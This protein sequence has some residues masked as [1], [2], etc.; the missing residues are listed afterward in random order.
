MNPYQ[1]FNNYYLRTPLLSLSEYQR[2][3]SKNELSEDDFKFILK[4]PI[5]RE[6]VF[7]ASPELHNQIE[8][9][10]KG[11]LRNPKKIERLKLSI[12]KYFTRISSR[13]TPFGLFAA[14]ELGSFGES[15]SI[16]L[17][18]VEQYK[19][20][21]RFD[22]AFLTQLSS[23][24][25]NDSVIR[26]H[27]L[28]YPNTSIYLIG[29]Q[30]R[31]HEYTI[32]KGRR[33]YSLEGILNSEYIEKVLENAKEGK[34]IDQLASVLVNEEVAFEEAKEFVSELVN[35]QVLM[36]ELEV[37]V[38]GE[39]Y[40][41]NLT[42]RISAYNS[43]ELL[44]GKLKELASSLSYID[45]S[46]G[47]SLDSYKAI[48]K[49]VKALVSDYN[50]NHLFQTDTFSS[51]VDNVLDKGVKKKLYNALKV[52]NKLTPRTARIRLIEFKRSF[53]KR[54]EGQQIPLSLVLDSETG[55]GYGDKQE[56]NTPLL[57][58]I[59]L[60]EPKKRYE[61]FVW[62]DV[63]NI[64]Q[65][66]LIET[67]SSGKTVMSLTEEDLK[68]IPDNWE[69]LPDTF[70][71]MIEIHKKNGKEAVYI[72]S[73]G[74]STALNL[75]GRFTE[76]DRKLFN[77]CKEIKEKEQQYQGDKIVAE[78]VHVPEARTGNV[79]H[80]SA[81]GAY[82]IPYLGKSCLSKSNQIPLEDIL[83][84]VK[85]DRVILFS[86][87]YQKEI[88]PKLSNA[89]NF[90]N[91]SLPIYQFLCDLQSQYLRSGL[92]FSWNPVLEKQ[93]FLP[94]VVFEDI[95]LCKAKWRI[96]T[97]TLHELL[98][99]SR[100]ARDI[101]KW[102]KK[103]QIPDYVVLKEG[104][105]ALLVYLKNLTSLQMLYSAVK[106]KESFVLEEHLFSD[107]EWVQREGELFC[108]QGIV[109]FYKLKG[110]TEPGTN[111]MSTKLNSSSKNDE[112]LDVSGIKETYLPGEEWLYYKVYCGIHTA[113]EL[114]ISC[115]EPLVFFLKEKGLLT[116]W[117]FIRYSDPDHHLRIRFLLSD[118]KD[119]TLVMN[120]F[121]ESISSFIESKQVWKLQVDCY[122][123]ELR[124]YGVNTID[125]IEQYFYFDSEF[126]ID[127]IKQSESDTD[128][129]LFCKAY[130]KEILDQ[131]EL[132]DIAQLS[133]LK[134]R[135]ASFLNE[136]KA[137]G[138]N[139]KQ[140]GSISQGL[141]KE[142]IPKVLIRKD[143]IIMIKKLVEINF[144]K[145][146]KV[147]LTSLLASLIHMTINRLFNSQQRMYEMLIYSCLVKECNSRLL[148][149]KY[150][151]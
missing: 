122:K 86:K 60:K 151:K 105:R 67:L 75:L 92:S 22:Y 111:Q 54:F 125:D 76:G 71:S 112:L 110:K 137:T 83:V 50:K 98:S 44:S 120:Y 46:F 96:Y 78:I 70:S 102:Q 4:Q 30:Y 14:C 56:S 130:I 94:R 20:R 135:D 27:L 61:R 132:S 109:S 143:Q 13:C 101:D 97:R 52:L 43:D 48:D 91:N 106:K 117:F 115:I 126:V 45:S 134:G 118:T 51:S 77:Y 10:E 42:K 116:K 82:E 11:I 57:D 81:L 140:L 62:T 80:R 47:Q 37:T 24:L 128:R 25:I 136:F 89:H 148:K 31:Y 19:R 108:N 93:F 18:S 12:L 79:I 34:T 129:L 23:K 121:N 63:D 84:T 8:N 9:W 64:L 133:F 7:L 59:S 17:N 144:N 40:F 15:T 141:K 68:K 55:I 87:R 85:N 95:I 26:E 16:K 99:S 131:F 72:K 69:D 124:R 150:E 74:G 149:S 32:E 41:T 73:M 33:F 123:R 119:M 127:T 38:T 138:E 29:N 39:D 35:N 65:E 113:D 21:T 104:D 100:S 3:I 66:K 28:F 107:D 114:L 142:L 147:P 90:N 139:K 6:A 36:S 1:L 88:L 49:K 2:F 146:L 145:E 5:F 58:N 53:N 103:L